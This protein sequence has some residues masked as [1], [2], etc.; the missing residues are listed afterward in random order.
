[1]ADTKRALLKSLGPVSVVVGL[2]VVGVANFTVSLAILSVLWL[3]HISYS[4]PVA[5]VAN[6]I[7]AV[8]VSVFGGYVVGRLSL[9]A[10]LTASIALGC[11]MAA[12]SVAKMLLSGAWSWTLVPYAALVVACTAA[13]GYL[14]TRRSTKAHAPATLDSAQLYENWR[15]SQRPTDLD[16]FMD[17]LESDASLPHGAGAYDALSAMYPEAVGQPEFEALA[18]SLETTV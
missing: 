7:G 12:G 5:I 11:I 18:A 13:G 4:S 15:S 14:A 6:M 2:V 16:A 10:P 17:G 3:S 8:V 1:V 9:K